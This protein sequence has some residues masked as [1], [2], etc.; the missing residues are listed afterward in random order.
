MGMASEGFEDLVELTIGLLEAEEVR[1]ARDSSYPFPRLTVTG[2]SETRN[3]RVLILEN[4]NLRVSICPA[5]GGRILA[6]HD[7]RTDRAIL[8]STCVLLPVADER[9]GAVLREGISFVCGEARRLNDLGSVDD[10]IEV[11]G[12]DE[13]TAAVW[14]AETGAGSPI[15]FHARVSLPSDKAQIVV[16]LRCFNRSLQ[17]APYNVGLF[18]GFDEPTVTRNDGGALIYCSAR[19]AGLLVECDGG[20]D[21]VQVS[22]AE[23]RLQ[24]FAETSSLGPRQLDTL[25][26]T[27]TP[28]SGLPSVE[29]FSAEGAIHLGPEEI[30]VQVT[31]P[32]LGAKLLL[33]TGADETLEAPVD[34]YPEHLL[35]LPLEVSQ[36]PVK[37]LVVRGGDRQELVRAE[38]EPGLLN[39]TPRGL[40][41]PLNVIE[42]DPEASEAELARA[43]FSVASRPTAWVMRAHRALAARE[44]ALA[45]ERLEQALLF[46]AE[47]HLAWWLKAMILRLRGR[48]GER[49]ELLNAH[50]LAPLE[51]ALKAEAFLGLSPEM[52]AEPHPLL[53]SLATNPGALVEVA[54]LLVE[55]GL[56]DQATRWIDEALRH[57]DLPM[58]RYLQA[59]CFLRSSRMVAE[60][61]QHLALAAMS[62]LGPPYPWRPIE[63]QALLALQNRF[64]KD[65]GLGRYLGL[66]AL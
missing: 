37:A 31:E 50:Y 60:A 47:D 23:V 51:P 52:G 59:Y 9:R 64:P 17:S 25:R 2:V 10:T 20:L 35:R 57:R 42:L 19:E 12:E 53:K 62:P 41:V 18:V 44:Y 30:C 27:L 65:A 33:L 61:S 8:P 13:Q 56:D 14:V 66:Q 3:F 46:N 22:D 32:V 24:R 29:G 6:I 63:W 49:P 1:S 39:T 40:S 16:E 5:L 45:D 7:K 28:I 38:A 54:A 48:E 43:C 36:C 4:P 15:G 55:A 21:H 58:L 26:L 34:L 11:A